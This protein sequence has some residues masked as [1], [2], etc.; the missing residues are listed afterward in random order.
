MLIKTESLAPWN[1]CSRVGLT[2]K[3]K[4]KQKKPTFY[5]HQ[6]PER[7][8][9]NQQKHILCIIYTSK[10]CA[11]WTSLFVN[12]ACIQCTVCF[13]WGG[14]PL[15]VFC[16]KKEKKDRKKKKKVKKKKKKKKKKAHK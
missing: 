9:K 4:K 12:M 8:N 11:S 5:L 3:K 16:L 2:K 10:I 1:L 14:V 15:F 7:E 6:T 13:V